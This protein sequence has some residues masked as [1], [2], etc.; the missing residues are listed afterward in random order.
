MYS[1]LNTFEINVPPYL[2]N[3]QADFNAYKTNTF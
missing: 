3:V 1:P 2:S